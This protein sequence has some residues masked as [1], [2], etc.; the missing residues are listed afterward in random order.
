MRVSKIYL[1]KRQIKE[2]NLF[3]CLLL[4]RLLEA[5]VFVLFRAFLFRKAAWDRH[6]VIDVILHKSHCIRV[7]HADDFEHH[8]IEILFSFKNFFFTI[9]FI[10]T[11]SAGFSSTLIIFSFF[12]SF[13]CCSA[14]ALSSW[15]VSIIRSFAFAKRS[16]KR[17][18]F[19]RNRFINDW[20]WW[21]MPKI[22]SLWMIIN[23]G[24]SSTIE[25]FDLL[26][27]TSLLH[28]FNDSLP[29]SLNTYQSMKNAALERANTSLYRWA[30]SLHK[31]N[32]INSRQ[33]DDDIDH[34]SRRIDLNR[35]AD[36]CNA[37]KHL[38]HEHTHV[39][40][41]RSC[42]EDSRRLLKLVTL[43]LRISLI[44]LKLRWVSARHVQWKF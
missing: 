32:T 6:R 36:V 25:I 7:L 1:Y 8:C 40:Q 23:D 9:L 39:C 15:I 24:A 42:T 31:L 14:A 10:F 33:Y 16:R 12:F 41:C 34:L 4:L 28:L 13:I 17:W 5:L 27:A 22:Y 30:K 20:L 43:N 29:S 38:R 21:L 18:F 26:E 44:L 19:R 35:D 11:F 2:R 3:I 37:D